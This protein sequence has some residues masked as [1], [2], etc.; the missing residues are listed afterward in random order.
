MTDV[1]YVT[2]LSDIQ[3]NVRINTEH[4]LDAIYVAPK[5]RVALAGGHT[6]EPNWLAQNPRVRVTVVG[7]EQAPT[8]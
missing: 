1:T 6:V 3:A 5:S 8:P 4:G 7:P 2:N